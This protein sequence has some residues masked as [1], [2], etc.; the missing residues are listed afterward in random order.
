M[1]A[2]HGFNIQHHMILPITTRSSSWTLPSVVQNLNQKKTNKKRKII[3][4]NHFFILFNLMRHCSL[5]L[6]FCCCNYCCYDIGL[7][8]SGAM[9]G[10]NKHLVV[11]QRL[12]TSIVSGITKAVLTGLCSYIWVCCYQEDAHT[13]GM[14]PRIKA[15]ALGLQGRFSTNEL[16][17]NPFFSVSEIIHKLNLNGILIFQTFL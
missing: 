13:C 14:V 17:L 11:A 1:Y 9:L 5:P 15:I 4:F 10:W 8:T 7:C 2:E 6:S 16:S 3:T 12:Y